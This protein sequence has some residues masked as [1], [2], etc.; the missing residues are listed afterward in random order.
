MIGD[1]DPGGQRR[2][3]RPKP[4]PSGI[5]L[6]ICS[7][8]GGKSFTDILADR[9]SRLPDQDFRRWS[10]SVAI[11]TGDCDLKDLASPESAFQIDSE[12]ETQ[13]IEAGP[14]IRA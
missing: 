2:R 14:K 12:R 6:S 1:H 11:P 7:S 9:R 4:L 5:S 13:G 10:E 8:I 3:A